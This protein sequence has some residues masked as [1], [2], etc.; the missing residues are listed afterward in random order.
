MAQLLIHSFYLCST[1]FRVCHADVHRPRRLHRRCRARR[2]SAVWK[3]WHANCKCTFLLQCLSYRLVTSA[4]YCVFRLTSPVKIDITGLLISPYGIKFTKQIF[5]RVLGRD[6][7]LPRSIGV[8]RSQP[9][10]LSTK[11]TL[12]FEMRQRHTS[13]ETLTGLN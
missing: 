4:S 7:P 8:T 3:I 1:I 13:H 9:A 5:L 2:S 6:R 11:R 10:T 12:C